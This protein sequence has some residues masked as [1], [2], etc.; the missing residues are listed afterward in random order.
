[1]HPFFEYSRGSFEH[2]FDSSSQL[3]IGGDLNVHLNAVIDTSGGKIEKKDSMRKVEELKFSYDLIDVWRIRNIDKRQYTW[4]QRKPFVQHRLDFWLVSNCLQ[5]V[6]EHT[7]IIPS[8]KS[9]HCYYATCK[10]Q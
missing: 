6:V 8:T 5:N 10:K 7:D 9:D 4:R 3:I 1:M 2:N